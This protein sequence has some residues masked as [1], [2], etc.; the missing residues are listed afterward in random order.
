MSN[1]N[2]IDFVPWGKGTAGRLRFVGDRLA[3][4]PARGV[5]ECR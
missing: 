5:A 4:D 2:T 3:L 1:D